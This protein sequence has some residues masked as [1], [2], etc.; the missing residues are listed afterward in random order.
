M[1]AQLRLVVA[2][3]ALSAK[4]NA[5]TWRA[6]EWTMVSVTN[7]K[8]NVESLALVMGEERAQN[9]TVS[10]LRKELALTAHCRGNLAMHV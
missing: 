7:A 1:H 5:K 6:L 9:I 2:R 4:G 3:S 10:S 8:T